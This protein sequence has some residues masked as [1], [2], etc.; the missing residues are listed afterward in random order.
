M[1]IANPIL[2]GLAILL[3]GAVP[4][5][6]AA[7]CPLSVTVVE[8]S[9]V[10][11][12]ATPESES[13]VYDWG[14]IP[15]GLT[16]VKYSGVGVGDNNILEFN[17]PSCGGPW[18]IDL[19]M[20]ADGSPDNCKSFCK[21]TVSCT[22]LCDECP[23]IDD[24]CIVDTPQWCYVCEGSPESL[25]YEWYTNPAATVAPTS[26]DFQGESVSWGTN[27]VADDKCYSP[28]L[29]SAAFNVPDDTTP[30]KTTWVVFVVR[31]DSDGNGIP[32]KVMKFCPKEVTLYW[33]ATT[34][35]ASDVS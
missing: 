12:T 33:Q 31:Q 2:I 10:K 4:M 30:I 1:K 13:Y 11:L 24:P 26:A 20:R 29:N 19:M 25:F 21:I 34:T 32:D 9:H 22:G 14:T 27:V 6:S 23:T 8:G 3:M 28:S 15:A 17:V 7:S 5:A 16:G 35:M 18:V